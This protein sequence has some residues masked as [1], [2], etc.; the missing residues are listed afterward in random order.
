[1]RNNMA[2]F[3]VR[4]NF[5]I[6]SKLTIPVLLCSV[7]HAMSMRYCVVTTMLSKVMFRVRVKVLK[8]T[9]IFNLELSHD[10]FHLQFLLLPFW[11]QNQPRPQ[12][13][14]FVKLEIGKNSKIGLKLTIYLNETLHPY[15]TKN[16]R[17]QLQ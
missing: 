3:E 1:M 4:H 8:V 14:F 2:H 16:R 15:H 5:N 9:F 6:N 13:K 11:R 7:N 10:S 12:S 17:R